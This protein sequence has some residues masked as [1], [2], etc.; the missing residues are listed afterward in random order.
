[1]IRLK[2]I[3]LICIL[4]IT[5]DAAAQPYAASNFTLVGHLDPETQLNQYGD[6]YSGCWGWYQASK[7]KEYAIACSSK[8]TYFVDITVPSTPTVSSFRIGQVTGATWRETKTYQNYC[9]V[10]SDDPGNNNSL[11]IFDMQY[12]PDSVHKVYDSHALFNRGHTLWVDGNKLY[13]AAASAG[14]NTFSSMSVYS[15]ANPANPILMRKLSQDYPIINYVHDMFVRNDTVYAS[16]ANQGLYIFKLMANNTFSLLG[17]LTSYPYSGFNHSSGLTP[18]GQTLVFTDEV[19]AGLPIKVANVSNF[20]NI[21]ILATTN[22]FPQTTPHNPFIV[23]NQYCFMSSYQDGLQLYDISTPS[24][25][26]LAGYF[27]TYPQAGGNNNTWPSG[28]DYEGQWG[29]YPYYPSRSIFALDESNGIFILKTHLYQ[30]TTTTVTAG[31]SSSAL[32]ACEG[33]TVNFF[34]NSTY[35]TNYLWTVSGGTSTSNTLTNLSVYFPTAGIYT[36]TLLSS[37]STSSATSIQTVAIAANNLNGVISSTDSACSTCS[38]GIISVQVSGGTFPFSYTWQPNGGHTYATANLAAGCY[39]VFIKDANGCMTSTSSCISFLS[40]GLE[41]NTKNN[42]IV[43]IYPNPAQTLLSI[44]YSGLTFNY[45]IYNRAGQLMGSCKNAQ[46]KVILS[47]IDYPKGLYI[48]E[49][50]TSKN[51]TSQ[52]IIIE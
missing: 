23:N 36:V 19:P 42:S 3:F 27:D 13:V 8:G 50:E 24:A 43:L 41:T 14:T 48:V 38:T 49:V 37:N 29:A 31:F 22:Q 15:L 26:F 25:P 5:S 17:S 51:K 18:D 45:A 35:A 1:M 34:N 11:Q 4:L 46:Q 28:G 30:S 52:K 6:K 21:Q 39:T 47:V 2:N 16:C 10:V 7:N 40:T 44:D 33:S 12:L 20:S 32:T 9:Y